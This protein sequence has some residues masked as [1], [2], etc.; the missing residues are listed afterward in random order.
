VEETAAFFDE[1]KVA[2]EVVKVDF[3]DTAGSPPVLPGVF[4]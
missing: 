4:D 3:L 2:L 1:E